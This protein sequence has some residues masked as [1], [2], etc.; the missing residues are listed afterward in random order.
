[1]DQVKR[2][3]I[4]DIFDHARNKVCGLYDSSF[5]VSGQAYNIVLSCERNGWKELSFLLP[6]ICETESG[7]EPNYRLDYLKADY[8]IRQIDDTGIDWYII[9]EP[10]IVHQNLSKNVSVSANHVAQLL[11]NKNLGQEFSDDEGNN[12]GTAR[13]LLTTILSGTGW[14]VGRVDTFYEKD[15]TTEKRRSLQASAKTGA[16]KLITQMC[17]L[18]DAKP[19]FNG[20]S[21]TV[22]I[23]PMNPFSKPV[24]GSLP[25]IDDNTGVIELHYGQNVSNIS[26]VL[27]T[28]NLVTKQYA[29]G[30]Y[31]DKTSGYCGID[32]CTHKEYVFTLNSPIPKDA[33]CTITTG[34]DDFLRFIP[35]SDLPAGSKLILSELDPLSLS[36]VWDETN[37]L[38]YR[39]I[40]GRSEQPN[41]N[42]DSE[43]TAYDIVVNGAIY[44]ISSR[45][46]MFQNKPELT[47]D[48]QK[49]IIVLI[50]NDGI[51]PVDSALQTIACEE[52]SDICYASVEI[53][54]VPN[55]FSFL[56]DFSYYQ[57]IG[58]LT[59][60][61]LQALARYQREGSLQ[62]EKSLN[63]MNA[64]I[65]A[66]G[67][68]SELIGSVDFCKLNVENVTTHNGYAKLNLRLNPIAYRT[69]YA[70]KTDDQFKWTPATQINEIGD[71]VN[72]VASILYIIHDTSPV[73]WDKVSIKSFNDGV[74]ESLDGV[75]Q[76]DVSSIQLWAELSSLR[77]TGNDSFY[78]F[79]LNNV[80]ALLGSWEA[81][82]E[83]K[84][85][86][87]N[88]ATKIVTSRHPVLFYD[89]ELPHID[90]D[91]VSGYAWAWKYN[92]SSAD[93][94]HLY[95]YFGDGSSTCYASDWAPVYYSASVPTNATQPAYWYNWGELDGWDASTLYVLTESGWT[96][97]TN[98][99]V[100][101]HWEETLNPDH[102][103]IIYDVEDTWQ[104]FGTIYNACVERD[105][106][107]KGY[108][109]YQKYNVTSASLTPG[110]YYFEDDYGDYYVFS[111]PE[112]IGFG[113]SLVRDAFN[114][115]IIQT[116]EHGVKTTLELKKKPFDGVMYD[117]SD[118]LVLII[119]KEKYTKLSP[120]SSIG[121]LRGIIAFIDRFNTLSD[122]VYEIKLAAHLAAQQE[123]L[124]LEKITVEKQGDLYRE[125]WWQSNDY[126]DGDENKLYDDAFDNQEKISQ[127]EANYTVTFL[128]RFGANQEAHYYVDNV[129]FKE[130]Y[131]DID[132]S[133]AAHLVDP[134]IAVN[135]WAYIDRLAKC[136]DLPWKTTLSINT[137][138][139]T[140]AQHSFTDVLTNIANVANELKG[141]EAVYKRA[142]AIAA[143]GTLSAER[144]QGAIDASKLKIF[145][146][147]STWYTD[148]SGNLIF[149]AADGTSAMTLTGNGQ[150]IADGKN[151][152]GE[153]N[154]RTFGTG[155]GFTADELT[156]GFLNSDRIQTNS[157]SSY[158][159]D[160]HTQ[161]ML[162]WVEGATI[163]QTPESIQATVVDTVIN[164]MEYDNSIMRQSIIDQTAESIRFEFNQEFTDLSAS[165]EFQNKQ[166]TWFSFSGDGLK[167]GSTMDSGDDSPFYSQQTNT[168]Y[169]FFDNSIKLLTITGDGIDM[170]EGRLTQGNESN[171]LTA[172]GILS[173]SNGNILLNGKTN[174]VT[175]GQNGGT[176][177]IGTDGT[178]IINLSTYQVKSGTE[179]VA[180][181][182]R[183]NTGSNAAT[184]S[185]SSEFVYTTT[186]DTGTQ[187]STKFTITTT[188]KK[189]DLQTNA[190]PS[191]ESGKLLQIVYSGKGQNIYADTAENE[192]I[193]SPSVASGHLMGWDQISA[194]NMAA[195]NFS[196]STIIADNM[197]LTDSSGGLISVADQK[198][199]IDKIVEILNNNEVI[200]SLKSKI[201]SAYWKAYHHSHAI[202]ENSDGTISIGEVATEG[203]S[204]NI[205]NTLTYKNGVLAA[206]E[207]VTLSFMGWQG[208]KAIV[209][210]SNDKRLEIDLPA[211]STS[212]GDSFA[213]NKTTV[214]FS[215]NVVTGP[216]ASKEVDA[217]PIYNNGWNDCL[218]ACDDV[219]AYTISQNAPGTLYVQSGGE[220]L[221]VGSSWVQVNRKYGVCIVP[222]PK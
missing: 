67:E 124:D 83:A 20:D 127:P 194:T 215:T 86:T 119:E 167:I 95:F 187:S 52:G 116:D 139:T 163:R 221:S 143:D 128:D 10:K 80:N 150:A 57:N 18:F 9:S 200:P 34:G 35:T 31:G 206:K 193:L 185:T 174:E 110:N 69:D 132:I 160:N 84:L 113:S 142:E 211:F 75:E 203:G 218:S 214:Y 148:A 78:L 220:Y 53:Q 82:D 13:E 59:D 126:V 19:I 105:R 165:K 43:T 91:S 97:A 153:W 146:G 16:F 161:E 15:Q 205:A 182:T 41:K 79:G 102:P 74:T 77:L 62:Q 47:A 27:N 117:S 17:N 36:Y 144:L 70:K 21:R 89:N 172:D 168:E 28:E 212:G 134:E 122:D 197:Y 40:D 101:S 108:T 217:T 195:N 155:K 202:K 181:D 162:Q 106:L 103:N 164:E 177:N 33:L 5:D 61:M 219:E 192:M 137:N 169:A 135:V 94:S 107:Y 60:E 114:G 8:L 65:E 201:D 208:G 196:G 64:Y 6:S 118:P 109:N 136:Y 129:V 68:L 213:A 7:S 141:K 63:A 188:Y 85:Q 207:S 25:E 125:G 76:Q 178:G 186:D 22:D 26:R 151:S 50:D 104:Y 175:I 48:Y 156:S 98:S 55:R 23:V 24:D 138:Q 12:V 81:A 123:F 58:L 111:L 140:M 189:A 71:P 42:Q 99:I 145:G 166:N 183:Y 87:L 131:P 4:L 176:V 54:N 90:I 179:S 133:Y 39:I 72:D 92:S 1:M 56:L 49:Y 199:T 100:A 29:Y 180:Y 3:L 73:T 14:N 88:E 96:K 173:L 147:N 66:Q 2:N 204:F 190:S 130:G 216:L 44:D 45:V 37:Q 30:S 32:E 51:V 171:K 121:D 120:T 222:D 115:W 170:L 159:L 38:A 198:W 191:I 154:W 210:S 93:R 149:V 112:S 157:I 158:K 184:S 209:E 152:S 46:D 11:K